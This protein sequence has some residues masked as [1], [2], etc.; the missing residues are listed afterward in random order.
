MWVEG[1]GGIQVNQ[2]R[3]FMFEQDAGSKRE[4]FYN[5]ISCTGNDNRQPDALFLF[6]NRDAQREFFRAFCDGESDI[7]VLS[8]T[9]GFLPVRDRRTPRVAT[10]VMASQ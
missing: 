1:Q 7:T 2:Y 3:G 8:P 4:E 10:R 6:A 9:T 5:Y